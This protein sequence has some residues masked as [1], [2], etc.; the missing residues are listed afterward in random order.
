M[1]ANGWLSVAAD[2]EIVFMSDH[3][4]K[5]QK[6]LAKPR[7][8]GPRHERCQSAKRLPFLQDSPLRNDGSRP[9]AGVTERR[10]SS[11]PATSASPMLS[12]HKAD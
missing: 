6:A 3:D 10:A 4:G 7:I 5:W 11:L 9:F 12:G 8:D 2:D 1:Q